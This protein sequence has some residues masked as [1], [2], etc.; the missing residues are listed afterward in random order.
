MDLGNY[1]GR[2]LRICPFPGNSDLYGIGIRIGFYLQWVSTLLTTIFMP[3]E[4]NVLRIL[5]LLIQSAVLLGLVLL[6]KEHEIHTIEPVITIWLL[7]GAL[8][9]LSGSG[10]NPLARFSGFFRVIIYSAVAGYACW[11]WFVGLDELLKKG[12]NCEIVAFF[13]GVPIDG[14]FRTFNK[15]A[16]ILGG[17]I[18]I[19]FLLWSLVILHRRITETSSIAQTAR[20]ATTR[21]ELLVLSSSII[22][23]SIAAVEYLITA[24]RITDIDNISSVGQL[25]PLISGIFG[26]IEVFFTILRKKLYRR[27]RCWILFG[28]HLS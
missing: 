24:N 9:S 7:F 18:C 26:L 10:M 12:L 23:L 22:A 27:H 20:T 28:R 3:T 25:I 1:G 4:E 11:F 6:T 17:I 8:S 13:G 2:F 14:P 15:V 16:S 21:V 5:N 19:A